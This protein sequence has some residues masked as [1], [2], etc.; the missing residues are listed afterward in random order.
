MSRAVLRDA[1]GGPE[2]LQVREVPEPHAGPGE[3]R[4]A[5]RAAG[6]NPMDWQIAG[7]AR[8]AAMFGITGTSG[9]G[10]DLAGVVD[11]VGQGVTEFAPG[12]R[13]YGGVLVGAVADHVVLR[14]PLAP[15]NLLRHTPDGIDDATAAALP[16]PGLTAAAALDAIRVG[17]SDTVLVGGAAGGVG[18]LAVQLARLAGATVIGTGSPGTFDFLE[19]LGAVP[20]TYGTGLADR[21]RA[22]APDGITA[23]TDLHGTETAETA[24]ALGVPPARIST[25]AA[26]RQLPGVHATGAFAADP[27]ALE[28]IAD[29]VAA[30]AVTV[31][32]AESFPLDRIQEAV[33]LQAGGHVHG[34]IVVTL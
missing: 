15:P 28:R 22:L 13:V 12:D 30:G 32:I 6:L 31:P 24:L 10:C 33:T 3:I 5:V 19:R 14:V 4:V 8:H 1:F 26:D 21:V 16:T 9:F 2:V 27:A 17:P 7:S 25:I 11:E 29:L 20:V 23:A 18:V 34:K